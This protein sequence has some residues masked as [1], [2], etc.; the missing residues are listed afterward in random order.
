MSNIRSKNIIRR[1]L[2]AMLFLPLLELSAAGKVEVLV[3]PQPVRT[4][5]EAYLIL[6]STDGS[7][8][9]PLNNR[10]PKVDGIDWQHGIRLFQL[11]ENGTGNVTTLHGLLVHVVIQG[12]RGGTEHRADVDVND[13]AI[14]VI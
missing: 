7:R 9:L 1:F 8:N 13:S 6:R 4:G 12:R 2:A 14:R 3:I 5:E 10:L 11:A